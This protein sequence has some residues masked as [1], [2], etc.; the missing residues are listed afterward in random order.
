MFEYRG[1]NRRRR[2]RRASGSEDRG[3]HLAN[4]NPFESTSNEALKLVPTMGR[5]AANGDSLPWG[6]YGDELSVTIAGRRAILFNGCSN[7]NTMA[8]NNR[9]CGVAP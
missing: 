6:T 2:I 8:A 4:A 9:R 3:K 5:E 1:F 7:E